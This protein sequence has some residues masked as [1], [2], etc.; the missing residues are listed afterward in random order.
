ML[1]EAQKD[2]GLVRISG[3]MRRR[4]MHLKEKDDAEW[5]EAEKAFNEYFQFAFKK[6]AESY[7]LSKKS[8]AES[9]ATAVTGN[10]NKN[11]TLTSTKDDE[12]DV[13]PQTQAIP[14]ES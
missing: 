6:R 12:I 4:S 7:A 10:K 1:D 3:A 2:D 13:P 8:E 14:M 11:L 5:T 9:A